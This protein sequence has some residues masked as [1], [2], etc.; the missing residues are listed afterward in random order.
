MKNELGRDE[1]LFFFFLVSGD[2]KYISHHDPKKSNPNKVRVQST[3][4][5]NISLLNPF[6]HEILE[7]LFNENKEVLQ[8]EKIILLSTDTFRTLIFCLEPLPSLTLSSG[9]LDSLLLNFGVLLSLQK[10]SIS[11]YNQ[12]TLLINQQ[13]HLLWP[14]KH[15][16]DERSSETTANIHSKMPNDLNIS[17]S[18]SN[19]CNMYLSS[20]HKK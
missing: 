3:C 7:I 9:I 13:R 8:F 4:P 10:A 2:E 15:W 1:I 17:A 5:H 6:Y 16:K 19:Y 20:I 14:R 11:R 18:F 12:P